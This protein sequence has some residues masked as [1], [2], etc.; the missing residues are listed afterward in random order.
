MILISIL[1]NELN[2]M[3]K[4][5]ENSLFSFI[6][7]TSSIIYKKINSLTPDIKSLNEKIKSKNMP[8]KPTF[9]YDKYTNQFLYINGED[10]I[11]LDTKFEIKT[12]SRINVNEKVKSISIEYNNK[13]ILYTTYNYKSMIINLLDL[14]AI[15]CFESKK[16]QYLGGFF[17]PYKNPQKEHDYFILCMVSRK[18]FNISR[19]KISNEQHNEL[20]YMS[21]KP[22]VS[23]N[24]K[25]ID[26]NFNHIFKLL[27]IIRDDPYSFCFYNLKSKCTYKTPIILNNIKIIEKE[28]KLYLEN[29]YKKLYLI[30][31]LDSVI[32]VYRLNDL[33]E[34]KEPL[35]INY[36]INKNKINIKYIFLQFYNSL[37]FIYMENFI[38][39]YDIKSK[40]N[41]Y[42]IFNLKITKDQ[43]YDTFY[44][45]RIVGKYLLINDIFY[46]IKFDKL[47][48]KNNSYSN[49]KDSFFLILRRNNCINVLKR[50][51]NEILNNFQFSIFLEIIEG[52][53]LNNKKYIENISKKE[54]N[55]NINCKNEPYKVIY[56]GNNSFF[57]SEDF[58]FEIF[59]QNFTAN[60]SPDILIKI[61]SYFYHIYNSNNIYLDIDLFYSSLF[62]QINKID[63]FYLI[64]NLIKNRMIPINEKLGVYLIMR[65]K[66]FK[67]IYQ[68]NY[69]YR[70]GIDILLNENKIDDN[71]IKNIIEDSLKINKFSDTFN[72]IADTYFQK[73]IDDIQQSEIK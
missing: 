35:K 21:N 56:I 5:N 63:N 6:P 44:K 32:E 62:C 30:H 14:E 67:D 57:V 53:V 52:I 15:E 1:I 39:I 43:F 60:I 61:L 46:K 70:I 8:F 26:Y 9:F 29:I 49:I 50:I 51:L 66:R 59:N 54:N 64:E 27:L 40:N 11:I 68:Y 47:N 4:N 7:E 65:A 45:A 13:Y 36:N 23:N 17:I 16:A 25:I 71:I 58:L 34:I 41:N 20:Q 2:N 3:K 69:C 22:F 19:I 72:L 31:L 18:Y 12:F 37:I 24:M 48:Y 38:K 42:E 73:T 33:K 10:V 55:I 28:S